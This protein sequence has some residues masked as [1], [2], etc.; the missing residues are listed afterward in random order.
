MYGKDIV[1]TAQNI[2][3]THEKFKGLHESDM[4]LKVFEM[5]QKPLSSKMKDM[6]TESI[7]NRFFGSK[8]EFSQKELEYLTQLDGI[9]HYEIG[10]EERN[11]PFRG[12]AIVRLA[13][14]SEDPLDAEANYSVCF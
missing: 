7:R 6:S 5:H 13:R 4:Y 14:S 2:I 10:I 11:R 3:N 8:R 1:E 9:N 12:V